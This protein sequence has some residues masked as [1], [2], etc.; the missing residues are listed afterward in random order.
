MEELAKACREGYR[1]AV[2]FVV[3]REDAFSFRPND[4]MD[5]AFG[6]A[7]RQA[8]SQG[9]KVQAFSCQVSPYGVMLRNDLPMFLDTP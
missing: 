6:K 1:A 9:V 8:V 2:I 3:Q 7:L 5:P 4:E